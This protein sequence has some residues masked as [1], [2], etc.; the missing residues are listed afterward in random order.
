MLCPTGPGIPLAEEMAQYNNYRVDVS[1]GYP[2]P[3]A[4]GDYCGLAD[5]LG[6]AMVTLEVPAIGGM[7]AW[8]D[9]KQALLHAIAYE[10]PGDASTSAA[11]E[12]TM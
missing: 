10:V 4:M 8:H 6:L 3:G 2:T 12:D 9:N 5:G 1:V 11:D 7:Q